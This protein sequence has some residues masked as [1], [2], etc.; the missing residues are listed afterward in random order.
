MLMTVVLLLAFAAPSVFAF[1]RARRAQPRAGSLL[2]Q[3]K[4]LALHRLFIACVVVALHLWF[5][6]VFAWPP[7]TGQP[8]PGHQYGPEFEAWRERAMS[9]AILCVFGTAAA[10]LGVGLV[11]V[12]EIVLLVRAWRAENRVLQKATPASLPEPST[13][14]LFDFGVGEEAW[15]FRGPQKEGYREAP[16]ILGWARGEPVV[17]RF[18]VG[19]VVSIVTGVAAFPLLGMDMILSLGD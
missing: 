14:T 17:G 2:A 10:L 12:R 11:F 16:E 7:P 8:E 6:L 1:W 18:I 19:P 15:V 4:Q 3:T 9:T 5:A 13:A